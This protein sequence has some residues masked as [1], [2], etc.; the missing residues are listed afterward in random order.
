MITGES[1][2]IDHPRTADWET[3][4]RL[5]RS[6]FERSGL[7]ACSDLADSECRA[8][9]SILEREQEAFLAQ[10]SSFR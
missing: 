10:E 9:M 8:L 5:E 6:V 7:A 4:A 2:G 3:N 1:R